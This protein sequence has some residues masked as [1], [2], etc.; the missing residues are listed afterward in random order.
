M[1]KK[2][3]MIVTDA[4]HPQINGVVTTI[5]KTW[6]E[7]QSRGYEV[8]IVEPKQFDNFPLW[9]YPEIKIAYKT[10]SQFEIMFKNLNPDY[11]HIATE[12]TLGLT[13][14]QWCVKNGF[15]FTTSYHTKFPEYIEDKLG[16]PNELS[17]I[18]MKWF[19]GSSSKILVTTQAMQQELKEKGI[20][21][22]AV[23]SRGVDTNLF[24]PANKISQEKPYLLYVGRISSE[25]NIE[26]FLECD[27][28]QYRKVLIGT[29]TEFK[30]LYNL[31]PQYEWLGARTGYDLARWYAGAECFVFP[32]LTDTFGLVMI[33]SLASGVPVAA[34]DIEVNQNIVTP[35]TGS[36]KHDLQSAILEAIQ[37][38]DSSKCRQ[39]VIDNFTWEKATD[40]FINS[41]IEKSSP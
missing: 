16:I 28:P 22:T 37:N 8:H 1:E 24:N 29:G 11:I 34:F 25:K 13:A 39:R 20:V 23:W 9:I 17:Y 5:E 3:I 14:R 12:G 27:L 38:K 4:W 7:L 6:R 2:R 10:K 30:Y 21:N 26:A 36:L 32:S 18:Y 33:E 15:K 40:N 31:Y 35:E 41:L 19:H